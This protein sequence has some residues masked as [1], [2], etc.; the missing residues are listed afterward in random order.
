MA[1]GDREH[2]TLNNNKKISLTVLVEI[3]NLQVLI[4]TE[5]ALRNYERGGA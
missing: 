5:E 2:A 3:A 4:R 1:L